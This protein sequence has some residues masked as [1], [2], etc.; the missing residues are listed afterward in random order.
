MC[1]IFPLSVLSLWFGSVWIVFTCPRGGQDL[2]MPH[3]EWTEFQPA[4]TKIMFSPNLFWYFSYVYSS[5]F[6][7]CQQ[8]LWIL[9][10]CDKWV[11]VLF[12][13]SSFK[14]RCV[15]ARACARSRLYIPSWGSLHYRHLADQ[16]SSKDSLQDLP[17]LDGP[18][19]VFFLFCSVI[20]FFKQSNENVRDRFKCSHSTM[21]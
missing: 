18:Y 1:V 2:F 12:S 4:Q 7:C 9:I 17:L 6:L 16:M 13:M 10:K 19:R 3:V 20:L 21:I 5:D 15:C 8:T 14:G 11:K